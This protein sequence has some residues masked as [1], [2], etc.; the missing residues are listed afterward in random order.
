MKEDP[1]P[2]EQGPLFVP[3]EADDRSSHLHRQVIGY[4]GGALPIAVYVVDQWRHFEPLPPGQALDSVS[5]YFYS[6]ASAIFTGVLACL[7]VF[8]LTYRG[9]AN[10]AARADRIAAL[11]AA[12]AA[13]GVAVFPTDTPYGFDP[14]PWRTPHMGMLHFGSAVILFLSFIYFSLFLFT[15]SDKRGPLPPDKKRRNAIHITCGI[16]MAI[17]VVGALIA[18][19]SGRAVVWYESAALWLFAVSWL[20]KGRAAWTLTALAK[21]TAHYGRNPRDLATDTWSALG[22]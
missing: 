9:Y 11:V 19:R 20:T 6:G 2:Q 21:K 15:K 18:G 16:G 22:E 10:E 5:A 12:L 4:L 1:P 3:A 7:A 13:I 14:L 8:L 17:C